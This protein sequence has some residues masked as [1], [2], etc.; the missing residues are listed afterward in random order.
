MP[1]LL[2]HT[3]FLSHIIMLIILK[4]NVLLCTYQN[5]IYTQI[6]AQTIIHAFDLVLDHINYWEVLVMLQDVS[7]GT[8]L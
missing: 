2:T 4:E 5:E 1:L 6:S 8:V 3:C 7:C